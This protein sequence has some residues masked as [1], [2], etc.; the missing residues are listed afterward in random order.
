MERKAGSEKKQRQGKEAEKLT[1]V[2]DGETGAASKEDEQKTSGDGLAAEDPPS[3]E[4]TDDA[5][6]KE[7]PPPV[8]AE[9]PNV[10]DMLRFSMDSPGGACV[11]SLSLMSLGLLSVSISIPKQMVV[12]DSTLVENNAVK[13]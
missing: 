5:P 8:S 3:G 9:P 1:E 10:S 7:E 13:R 11:A 4:R 2:N 12:V 6:V